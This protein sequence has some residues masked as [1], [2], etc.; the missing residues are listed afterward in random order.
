MAEATRPVSLIGARSTKVTPS[1]KSSATIAAALK[2]SRVLPTPPGPVKVRR[3]TSSRTN[4]S[5]TAASSRSRP[6][7][8]VRGGT[9]D[10][11]RL[12]ESSIAMA[13]LQRVTTI[14][15]CTAYRISVTTRRHTAKRRQVQRLRASLVGVCLPPASRIAPVRVRHSERTPSV[16]RCQDLLA[17]TFKMAG[18]LGPRTGC[19]SAWP[20]TSR[21]GS[22]PIE[23]LTGTTAAIPVAPGRLFDDVVEL[24]A[25]RLD[26]R[27]HPA[28]PLF[29]PGTPHRLTEPLLPGGEAL[30]LGLSDDGEEGA[31][32]ISQDT[33]LR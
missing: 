16:P 23:R 14:R 8:G 7:S 33:E 19:H 27:H 30:H 32:G 31:G 26:Q 22:R 10:G 9:S 24:A 6:I 5:R 21:S 15:Q 13:R 1:G 28:E 11:K 29:H 17:P 2:A 20:A 3:G 18:N 12:T 25:A 4:R